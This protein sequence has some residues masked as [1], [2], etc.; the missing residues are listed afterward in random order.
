MNWSAPV[1]LAP[2]LIRPFRPPRSLLLR[3]LTLGG[4]ASLNKGAVCAAAVGLPVVLPVVHVMANG[5]AFVG[6]QEAMMLT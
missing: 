6:S 3:R 4:S 5:H 1:I 2:P